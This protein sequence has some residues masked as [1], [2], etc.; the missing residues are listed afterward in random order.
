MYVW[1]LQWQPWT[2]VT[3]GG[4][5][6][7]CGQVLYAA[8]GRVY[9]RFDLRKDGVLDKQPQLAVRACAEGGSDTEVE[10]LG[11][12]PS[13]ESLLVTGTEPPTIFDSTLFHVKA[14]LAVCTAA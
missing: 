4:H 14:Q 1:L 12:H 10:C 3:F 8:A 6:R 7:H 9:L 2:L 13:G 11:L 5:E